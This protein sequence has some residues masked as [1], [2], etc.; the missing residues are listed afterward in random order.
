MH[1]LV[2]PHHHHTHT[3]LAHPPT[4]PLFTHLPI[5]GS[6]WS[7]CWRVAR[8]RASGSAPRRSRA[9][10]AGPRNSSTLDRQ[11]ARGGAQML[12]AGTSL[13]VRDPESST[14]VQQQPLCWHH[15]GLLLTAQHA[16]LFPQVVTYC[17]SARCRR[18]FL[19]AH[20]GETLAPTRR[21]GC[22]D[23]CDNPG[24][25]AAALEELQTAGAAR[26]QR[27]LGGRSTL[28]FGGWVG[29]VGGRGGVGVGVQRARR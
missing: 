19:L 22:C 4:H 24:R 28:E 18:S 17:L 6:L 1:P 3:S 16:L 9:P 14:G 12:A 23:V 7:T 8:P 26:R 5:A 29:G 13:Y 21:P 25:V 11:A 10:T 27:F 20:F 2:T 15:C